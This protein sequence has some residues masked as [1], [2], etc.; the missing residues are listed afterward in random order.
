MSKTKSN[1]ER[2]FLMKHI[3]KASSVVVAAL[4]ASVLSNNFAQAATSDWMTISQVQSYLKRNLGNRGSIT[5]I[6]CADT[7]VKGGDYTSFVK[8]RVTHQP[9]NLRWRWAVGNQK[10]FNDQ[11]RKAQSEGLKVVSQSSFTRQTSGVRVICA[12]FGQ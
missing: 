9:S 8:I 7:G 5:K 2:G 11:A 10:N 3:K 12:A 4:A 1:K 6:E